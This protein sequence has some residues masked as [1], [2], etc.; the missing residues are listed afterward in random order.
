MIVTLNR[1]G[2]VRENVYKSSM[3]WVLPWIEK[4]CVKYSDWSSSPDVWKQYLPECGDLSLILAF[5]FG[6]DG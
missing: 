3:Y 5:V 6:D 4:F 2:G 1:F